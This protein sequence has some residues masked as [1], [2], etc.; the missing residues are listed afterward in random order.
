MKKIEAI[1]KILGTRLVAF[2]EDK[3]EWG[4]LTEWVDSREY[5]F[6]VLFC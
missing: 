5:K 4:G 1:E 2:R 3:E 6:K